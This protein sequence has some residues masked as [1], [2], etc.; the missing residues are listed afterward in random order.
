MEIINKQT[1]SKA[2][3][4]SENS[5]PNYIKS[6]EPLKAN[7]QLDVSAGMFECN[8]EIQILLFELDSVCKMVEDVY[9]NAASDNMLK[10]EL[11]SY[12]KLADKKYEQMSPLQIVNK[13]SEIAGVF[14][15]YIKA[16]RTKPAKK[17]LINIIGDLSINYKFRKNA[18]DQLKAVAR[19]IKQTDKVVYTMFVKYFGEDAAEEFYRAYSHKRGVQMWIRSLNCPEHQ[20][21]FEKLLKIIK[22]IEETE[23]QTAERILELME[24]IK[25]L[26]RKALNFRNTLVT[27]N[28]KLVLKVASKMCNNGI[29][30]NDCVQEGS[31][32]LMQATDLFNPYIG[33]RFVTFAHYWIKNHIQKYWHSN[34]SL[35]SIPSKMRQDFFKMD[36]LFLKHKSLDMQG[37]PVEYVAGKTGK[38][39]E[40]VLSEM[41][42]IYHGISQS[43][44]NT[45]EPT[46]SD[47]D[48]MR[49]DFIES[50]EDTGQSVDQ[51]VDQQYRD[52]FLE[53]IYESVSEKEKM[54]WDLRLSSKVSKKMGLHEFKTRTPLEVS[55]ERVRQIE[56]GLIQKIKARVENENA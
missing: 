38:T 54:I 45:N 43:N 36:R 41:S 40:E 9:N 33:F 17:A 53:E 26:E 8:R 3:P 6:V 1:K 16:G 24:E 37:S 56:A 5:V 48:E 7:E 49:T 2:Q 11:F 20:S 28:M 21:G 42:S 55:G 46:N 47:G 50:I 32:G 18:I 22:N 35:V 34:I 25:I 44:C 13:V 4:L 15:D 12:I 19:E 52:A 31:I 14:K 30:M 39:T 10:K 23:G 27:T 29:S 51:H